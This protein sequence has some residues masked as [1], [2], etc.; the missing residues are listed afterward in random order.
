[1]DII[2][3]WWVP[4]IFSLLKCEVIVFFNFKTLRGICQQ[5]NQHFIFQY[6]QRIHANGICSY[7]RWR[8]IN[9]YIYYRISC[10]LSPCCWFISKFGGLAEWILDKPPD[11]I[12]TPNTWLCF[13]N[14][15]V[16]ASFEIKRPAQD[17]NLIFVVMAHQLSHYSLWHDIQICLCLAFRIVAWA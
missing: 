2:H 10:I 13:G 14:S 11:I 17:N 6:F 7:R 5:W 15:L 9:K 1:M 12:K 16:Y 3:D 4:K 8:S